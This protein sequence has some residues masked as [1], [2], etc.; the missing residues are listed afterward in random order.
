MGLLDKDFMSLVVLNAG[1]VSVDPS[2]SKSTQTVLKMIKMK[3]KI[4]KAKFS[5]Y[6]PQ[7]TKTK[8][9]L[10]TLSLTFFSF[11]MPSKLKHPSLAFNV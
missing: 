10:T 9:L 8:I 3:A 6:F 7:C 4:V 2:F 1:L 5:I 11:T